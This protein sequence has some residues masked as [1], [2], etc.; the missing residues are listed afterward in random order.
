M[1]PA[2]PRRSRR[3]TAAVAA[4]AVAFVVAAGS[5]T[6]LGLELSAALD[7]KEQVEGWL[8]ATEGELR[9]TKSRLRQ[10][11]AIASRRKTVLLQADRV[12][13]QVDPLLSSVD[14]MKEITSRMT[15]TQASFASNA[16]LVVSSLARLLDYT[17]STN[18]LYWDLPYIY[19]LLDDVEGGAASAG[20]DQDRF[21][22]LE[23]D[24]SAASRTFEQRATRYVRSVER[25]DRQLKRVT[26]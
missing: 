25:L 1:E 15:D 8:A 26:G 13:R 5:S 10:S 19:G 11:E 12:L 2:R 14:R 21:E 24:Y 9:A 6:F 22:G 16:S 18:P 4:L 20:R 23:R 17:V 7:E 3:R